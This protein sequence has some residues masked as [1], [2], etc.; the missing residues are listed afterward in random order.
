VVWP[1]VWRVGAHAA[2]AGTGRHAL[3]V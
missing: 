3:G 1:S 2:G